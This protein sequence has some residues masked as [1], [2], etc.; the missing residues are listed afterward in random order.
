[1]LSSEVK[2]QP[3]KTLTFLGSPSLVRLPDGV[4]VA[5][6]D[7]FGPGCPRNHEAE[8]SLTSI[9]RSED[10]GQSWVN[11]THVMNAFCSEP[12]SSTAPS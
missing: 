10:N 1:M 6:H 9:Y 7:Y 12:A 3:E 2:Y 5:S 11:V 4:L 8:E